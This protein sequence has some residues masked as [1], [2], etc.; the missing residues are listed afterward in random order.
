MENDSVIVIPE[1]MKAHMTI[2][3]KELSAEENTTKT[4]TSNNPVYLGGKRFESQDDLIAYTQELQNKVIR[5]DVEREL[6][7]VSPII[8]N[9]NQPKISD[10]MFSDPEAFVQAMEENAEKRVFDRLNKVDAQKNVWNGFY[11]KYPELKDKDFAPMVEFQF[12]KRK[13][14]LGHLPA[15]QLLDTIG[16]DMRSLVTKVR[17]KPDGGQELPSGNAVVASSANTGTPKEKTA[18]P[19]EPETMAAQMRRFQKRG[20]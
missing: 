20:K 2:G 19:S 10:L 16:K 17:G 8:Q 14:E 5:H 12:N 9:A 13:S 7:T 11:D 6:T 3:K 18:V 4:T 15:D 1:E